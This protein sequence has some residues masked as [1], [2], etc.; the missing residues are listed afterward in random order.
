VTKIEYLSLTNSLSDTDLLVVWN[1]GTRAI[2]AGASA[3]YYQQKI[4]ANFQP[5]STML[6]NLAQLGASGL[7]NRFI[8]ITGV[9]TV[10]A[11]S[12][13]NLLNNI[14]GQP[15]DATLTALAGLTVGAGDYIEATG[16]DTFQTRKLFPEA[17]AAQIASITAAI[18]TTGKFRGQLVWDT[19][20]NRLLRASGGGASDPWYLVGWNGS[21]VT[22]A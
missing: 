11:V 16:V 15:V 1:G 21:Q 5:K 6:T 7:P 12:A 22:P 10:A 20:N 14:G 4:S 19:T 8:V 18:N 9:N 13:P 3:Q 2:Q 17:T